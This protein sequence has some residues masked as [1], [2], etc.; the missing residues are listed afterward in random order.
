MAELAIFSP[1][2]TGKETSI[3]AAPVV[4]LIMRITAMLFM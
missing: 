1:S 2:V 4:R 3:M